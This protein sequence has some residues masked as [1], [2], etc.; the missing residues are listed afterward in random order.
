M[1]SYDFDF[2][3]N[4]D[5][6]RYIPATQ[7]LQCVEIWTFIEGNLEP[8][9]NITTVQEDE[10]GQ[11]LEK[12]PT[13]DDAH[14]DSIGASLRLIFDCSSYDYLDANVV[15]LRRD[16]FCSML[17]RF[18]LPKAHVDALRFGGG[19]SMRCNLKDIEAVGYYHLESSM[20]LVFTHNSAAVTC[21]YVWFR[22]SYTI[23]SSSHIEMRARQIR[24][25]I[26]YGHGLLGAVEKQTG[27]TAAYDYQQ[28]DPSKRSLTELNLD[29]SKTRQSLGGQFWLLAIVQDL[30]DT[31]L[32]WI[33][34]TTQ[35]EW[36][37][38]Q[39]LLVQEGAKVI[40]KERLYI[41]A[42]EIRALHHTV[43][44]NETRAQIQQ[45][46]LYNLI[47]REDSKANIDIATASRAIA[48]ASRR[49]SASMKTI[50]VLTMAFLPATWIAALFAMPLFNWNGA[51][52][53]PIIYDRFWI[54][55]ALTL[56]LTTA[57]LSI[58]WVWKEWRNRKDVAENEAAE[59]D[60]LSEIETSDRSVSQTN[61][62]NAQHSAIIP[63][64][65]G[66]TAKHRKPVGINP[67]TALA[68]ANIFSHLSKRRPKRAPLQQISASASNITDGIT[69]ESQGHELQEIV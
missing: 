45:S 62:P 2:E 41:V 55:W 19:Q 58:W 34:Q 1:P 14:K 9:V 24:S 38:K 3:E 35:D 56:P 25:R 52:G 17:S 67:S 64:L 20:N 11:W 7:P 27:H 61:S 66:S 5:A 31:I 36:D 46:T 28:F 51:P 65:D 8:V 16:T 33:D 10:L 57:V 69:V 59:N 13:W 54:Y 23:N 50:A 68:H 15:S 39:V 44:F 40:L 43:T 48:L 29:M 12:E 26:L 53:E 22:P 63:H 30:V 37:N 32:T 49:D 18:N 6:L 60:T 4:L 21:G 47:A 42:S